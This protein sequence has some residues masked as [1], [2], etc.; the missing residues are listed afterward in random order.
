MR[1]PSSKRREPWHFHDANQ[2]LHPTYFDPCAS[3]DVLSVS[4]QSAATMAEA[5]EGTVRLVMFYASTCTLSRALFPTF[6]AISAEYAPQGLATL[7]FSTDDCAKDLELFL[8]DY[9]VT[10]TPAVLLPRN[11]GD[12][13][14][15]FGEMGLVFSSPWTKPLVAVVGRDGAAARQWSPTFGT[16]A[17]EIRDVITMELGK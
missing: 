16:D 9:A 7:A 2:D 10:F 11:D 5:H 4:V 17:P 12:L 14:A 3:E 13:T 8:A 6:V 1:S 15:A